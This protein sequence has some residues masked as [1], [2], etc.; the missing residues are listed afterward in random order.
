MQ[1]LAPGYRQI[2]TFHCQQK[3][4]KLKEEQW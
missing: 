4:M 1:Q 3:E 2:N